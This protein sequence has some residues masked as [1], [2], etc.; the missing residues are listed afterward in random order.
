MRIVLDTN[1]VVSGMLSAFGPPCQILELVVSGD[2]A[3]VVDD[4]VLAEYAEVLARPRLKLD[5]RRVDDFLRVA[6]DA[7]AAVAT[8]LP[9]SLPDPADEAFLEIAIA[10][11]VDALVTGNE[12][13]FKIPGGKL[14]I[15]I[16]TPRRFLDLLSGR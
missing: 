8:P 9:F 11:A 2:V 1:V 7:D 4:R 5:P 15:P 12:K 6:T 14:A 3:L 16:L 10:G 13:H